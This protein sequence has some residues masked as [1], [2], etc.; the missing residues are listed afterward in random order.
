MEMT[1]VCNLPDGRVLYVV[2]FLRVRLGLNF[3]SV[4]LW[5]VAINSPPMQPSLCDLAQVTAMG[6]ANS[7]KL[8]R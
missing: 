1:V 5:Q 8:K 4:K 7:L 2:A 6:S 3:K